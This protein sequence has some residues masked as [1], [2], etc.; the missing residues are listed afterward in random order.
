MS[1]LNYCRDGGYLVG[2]HDELPEDPGEFYPPGSPVL[3]GCNHMV[4]AEC[5]Q[6]VRSAAGLMPKTNLLPRLQAI[7]TAPDWT[8]LPDFDC[9]PAY[10]EWRTYV[11]CCAFNT[12]FRPVPSEH[13]ERPSLRWR[14]GGHPPA[15][16]GDRVLGVTLDPDLDLGELAR[17]ALSGWRPEQ[18]PEERTHETEAGAPP[19]AVWLRRLY[20][21]LLGT[22]MAEALSRGVAACLTHEDPLVRAR[23]LRFFYA[24]PAAPGGERITELV[25]G[26]RALFRGQPNPFPTEERDLEDWL[27]GAAGQRLVAGVVDPGLAE[28]LRAEALR[29]GRAAPTLE[30]LAMADRAWLLEHAEDI[31]AATPAICVP[32]LRE[33]QRAGGTLGPVAERLARVRGVDRAALRELARDLPG[34]ARRKLLAALK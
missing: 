11:C 21:R 8:S 22:E 29:P 4:C 18:V 2:G 34:S 17:R 33:L 24:M 23:A 12:L 32:L 20:R 27:I 9:S 15:A 16:V 5:G 3:C 14:C 26:D 10:A 1:A 30:A 28:L 6:P 13:P 19:Q 31:V 25:R 7:Y